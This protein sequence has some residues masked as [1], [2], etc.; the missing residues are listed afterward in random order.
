MFLAVFLPLAFLHE[1]IL[2]GQPVYF[3]SRD[4]WIACGDPE[5]EETAGNACFAAFYLSP[6]PESKLSPVRFKRS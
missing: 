3:F 1:T 4:G 2:F 5:K 6:L